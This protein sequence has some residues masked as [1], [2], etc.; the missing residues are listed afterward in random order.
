M[1]EMLRKEQAMREAEAARIEAGRRAEADRR[2][3]IKAL[4]AT[5][6]EC[7]KRRAEV[8][9]IREKRAEALKPDL[10][11]EYTRILKSRGSALAEAKDGACLACHVKLRAQVF[12]DVR[13]NNA[14]IMCS[15][16]SRIMFFDAPPPQGALDAP[17]PG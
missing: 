2:A 5:I 17:L 4:E 15:S 13:H 3:E 14:I 11:A 9:V 16:C 1:E 10:L 6:Q 7:E 8:S 12:V